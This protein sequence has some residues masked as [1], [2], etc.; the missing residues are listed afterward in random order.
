M[1]KINR[2]Y[3][4]LVIED[5]PD[6]PN[7]ISRTLELEGY[8]VLK[9]SY[10]N[11]GLAIL[12]EYSIDLILFDLRLLTGIDGLLVLHEIK[13][14]REFSEIPVVVITAHAEPIYRQ[15]SLRMGATQCLIKPLSAQELSDTIANVLRKKAPRHSL[16][17]VHSLSR[18]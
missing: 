5:E 3:T 7:F 17:K 11:A 12:N 13:H 10:N 2:K 14:T 1:V 16:K 18:A 8:N 4:V 9:T 6:I 15:R